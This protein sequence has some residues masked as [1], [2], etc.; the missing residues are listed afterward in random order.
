[1]ANI[2]KPDLMEVIGVR[3]QTPDVKSVSLRFLDPERA[4][5]FFLSTSASSESSP[6]SATANPRSTSV[7]A[8]TGRT[9]SNSV[10]AK[11]AAS[12]KRCGGRGG[13]HHRF[14][15]ALR[16]RLPHGRVE[17]HDLIFLG[18]GIAMP[19]IRCAVWYALENRADYGEITVVYGA[20]TVADLVYVDELDEWAKRE[21]VRV[22]QCVDPG[23]E[24]P[25]WKG[26]IGFV[27][28]SSSAP[29]ST[30]KDPDGA[31]DRPAHHDQEHP[32]DSGQDGRHPASVYT[33]IENRMKCGV[34]KCGRCNVGPIY[35]CK[36]GPVFTMEQLQGCPPTT[37]PA[38]SRSHWR[39]AFR[40]P[41][42]IMIC[43]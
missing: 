37:D 41:A 11:S 38:G 27:P 21:R 16:Q 8:R 23:G 31:G 33:S 4:R 24:T 30:A 40:P 19:P 25:D 12:P 9:A 22:I 26:E 5:N 29:R 10:S 32:A 36:E 17:G 7:P 14:P 43:F 39:I 35:V 3:Q 6:S 20:R 2:Y 28:T 1:M 13:R 42:K 18:G 15:R 34:G